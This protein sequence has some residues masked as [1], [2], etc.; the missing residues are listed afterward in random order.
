MGFHPSED[1][2]EAS[3]DFSAVSEVRLRRPPVGRFVLVVDDDPDDRERAAEVIAAEG[4]AVVE[5]DDGAAALDLLRAMKEVPAAILLDWRMPRMN[6]EGLLGALREDRVLRTLRVVVVSGDP[7]AALPYGVPFVP[8][9]ITGA[10]LM[11]LLLG[12][13]KRRCATQ[14]S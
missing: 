4:Y 3:D 6:G 10:L 11:H 2:A 1:V 7:R 9:P 14:G 12:C 5:A 8:K 13:A